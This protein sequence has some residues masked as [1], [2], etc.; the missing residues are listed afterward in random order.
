MGI[1]VFAEVPIIGNVTDNA[2]KKRRDMFIYLT[3]GVYFS[4]ILVV[5]GLEVLNVGLID[6]AVETI[7]KLV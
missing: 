6:T 5:L 2:T 4:L 3:S 1:P 7:R